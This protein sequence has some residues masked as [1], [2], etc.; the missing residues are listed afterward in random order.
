MQL[1]QMQTLGN[2]G[3]T[4]AEDATAANDDSGYGGDS[5]TAAEDATAVLMKTLGMVEI[6]QQLPKM[7][8]QQMKTLGMVEILQQLPKMQQQNM[9]VTILMLDGMTTKQQLMEKE[10]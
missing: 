10:L 1:Q 8:Q 2:D 5:T 4:A 3:T 6:L 7:Q 9:V